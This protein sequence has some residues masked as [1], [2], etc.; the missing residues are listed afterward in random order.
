MGAAEAVPVHQACLPMPPNVA[1]GG[2]ACPVGP[3]AA[4]G[5]LHQR[6]QRAG[7]LGGL[8]EAL[9]ALEVA[10]SFINVCTRGGA[11]CHNCIHALHQL[12]VSLAAQG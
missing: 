10:V 7:V 4:H 1:V 5:L 6:V 12:L 8:D 9:F 2:P 11:G 3:G